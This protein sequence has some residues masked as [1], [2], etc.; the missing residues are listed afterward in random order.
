MALFVLLLVLFM[1]VVLLALFLFPPT[2]LAKK[3]TKDDDTK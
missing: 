1:V 2:K 3:L